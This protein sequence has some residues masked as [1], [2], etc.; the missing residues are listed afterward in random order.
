MKVRLRKLIFGGALS[1]V[2]WLVAVAPLA[3]QVESARARI[4]G[5][6]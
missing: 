1:G 2:I 4:D 6:T 5:M 3:A